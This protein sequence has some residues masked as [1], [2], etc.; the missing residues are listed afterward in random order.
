MC[1]IPIPAEPDCNIPVPVASEE[2]VVRAVWSQHLDG[3][4]L[5]KSFFKTERA[6]VMRHTYMGT[7]ACRVQAKAIVPGN[8]S[9]R[10]KGLAI[11][12]VEKFRAVGS[13]I[14]DSREIYCGHAHVEHGQIAYEQ[15]EP[16]EPRTGPEALMMLDERL[17][18]LKEATRWFPDLDPASEHWSGPPVEPFAL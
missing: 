9:L 10:Y 18:K 2:N 14:V 17:R 3:K 5:K 13:D 4:S 15:A 7:E 11:T 1:E 12:R 6:S 8:P 16:G